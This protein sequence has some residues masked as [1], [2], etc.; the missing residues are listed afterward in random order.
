MKSPFEVVLILLLAVKQQAR[1]G[2]NDQPCAIGRPVTCKD[3]GD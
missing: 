1:A 3:G 2:D